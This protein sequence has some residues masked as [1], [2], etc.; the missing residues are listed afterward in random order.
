MWAIADLLWGIL[1]LAGQPTDASI[2]DVLYVAGY[3]LLA[4]G[5]VSM[6]RSGTQDHDWGDIVDAGIIAVSAALVLWP[7]V[8]EPSSSSAGARPRSS[9]WR[10]RRATSCCS[11]CSRLSSSRAAGE[12]SPSP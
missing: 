5:L 11:R 10:T 3:V 8:F 9:R 2:A 4:V 1:D 7:I 6:L 12:R